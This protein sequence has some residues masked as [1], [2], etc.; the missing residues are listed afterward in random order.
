MPSPT[1]RRRW[2]TVSSSRGAV[3]QL[4]LLGADAAP[5]AADAASA[6]AASAAKMPSLVSYFWDR[7][8]RCLAGLAAGKSDRLAARRW[9]LQPAV[10]LAAALAA[11]RMR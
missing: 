6:D 2:P 11:C 1:K 7:W 9:L 3:V 8:R 5:A 4:L 10:V